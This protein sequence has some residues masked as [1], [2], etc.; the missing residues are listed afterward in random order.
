MSSII[1]SHKNSNSFFPIKMQ[2]QTNNSER[3]LFVPS[4]TKAPFLCGSGSA[5]AEC[6]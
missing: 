6:T 3:D 4:L 2:I 1:V 5:N